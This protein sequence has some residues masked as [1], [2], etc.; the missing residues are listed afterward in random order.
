M[1]QLTITITTLSLILSLISTVSVQACTSDSDCRA[2]CRP[3]LIPYCINSECY[4]T[5]L[6][7]SKAAPPARIPTTRIPIQRC[8]TNCDCQIR[9]FSGYKI[10][11][12]NICGCFSHPYYQQPICSGN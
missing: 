1:K 9:C 4:C 3:G 12:R 10:C 5:N 8:I 6:P 7:K 2:Q 11:H